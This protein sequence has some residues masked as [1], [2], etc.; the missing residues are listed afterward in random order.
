[1]GDGFFALP[2]GN[3]CKDSDSTIYP[4]APELCDGKDNDCDGVIPANEADADNDGYRICQGDCNDNN[5]N[6]N[7]GTPEVCDDG[8]DNDCDGLIDSDDPDCCESTNFSKGFPL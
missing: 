3:D 6:I 2:C 5:P 7:P 4:G 1:M 8:I